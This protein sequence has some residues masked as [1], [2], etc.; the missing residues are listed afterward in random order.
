LKSIRKKNEFYGL[1]WLWYLAQEKNI[2]N[3]KL[4]KT[5]ISALGAL[6]RD[7]NFKGERERYIASCIDSVKRGLSVPQSLQILQNLLSSYTGTTFLGNSQCI[8]LK[9]KK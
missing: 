4:I 7:P 2:I 5:V 6:F 3:P 9:F 1:K 8:S